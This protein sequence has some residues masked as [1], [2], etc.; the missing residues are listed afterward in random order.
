[1]KLQWAMA[2]LSWDDKGIA[3]QKLH[4][5]QPGANGM[6]PLDQMCIRDRYMILGGLLA[7]LANMDSDS[8]DLDRL[9]SR[10]EEG[11]VHELILM[12]SMRSLWPMKA[13]FRLSGRQRKPTASL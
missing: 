11:E 5:F 13:D 1:M 6:E 2:P 10:L 9:I 4:L 7:P 3:H 12:K 8:L